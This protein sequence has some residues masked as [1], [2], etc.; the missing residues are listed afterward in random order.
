MI[1][2]IILGILITIGILFVLLAAITAIAVCMYS[3]T[4]SQGEE[5]LQRELDIELAAEESDNNE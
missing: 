5:R 2:K 4:L 3:S 1:A